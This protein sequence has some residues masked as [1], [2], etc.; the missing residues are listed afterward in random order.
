M[1]DYHLNIP[2]YLDVIFIKYAL[3]KKVSIWD[4][5]LINFLSFS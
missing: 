5:T 3:C 1:N 2:D 4:I